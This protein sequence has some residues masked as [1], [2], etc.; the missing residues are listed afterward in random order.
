MCKKNLS[1]Y[2]HKTSTK[3]LKTRITFKKTVRGEGENPVDKHYKVVVDSPL[4]NKYSQIYE[5]VV[6]VNDQD[7]KDEA[8]LREYGKQ[9]FRTTL[10]DLLEDSI[11]I[12]VIGKSDVSTM[13]HLIW[14]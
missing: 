3:S 6:E 11:E 5:D 9:Y 2:Q 10:C 8:S 4:I 13:K 7:V 12:D 1:T 14:T